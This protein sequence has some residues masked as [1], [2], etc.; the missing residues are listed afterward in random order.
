MAKQPRRVVS[1]ATYT[2]TVVLKVTRDRVLEIAGLIGKKFKVPAYENQT[3]DVLVPEPDEVDLD[4]LSAWLLARS[5]LS[6]LAKKKTNSLLLPDTVGRTG[7]VVSR[8]K[9]KPYRLSVAGYLVLDY[10]VQ[11]TKVDLD[12]LYAR[13][14]PENN[15]S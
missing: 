13:M 5:H 7:E 12:E 2:N 1:E 6:P 8:L 3:W 14:H 15:E 4:K 9:Q 11:Q 10:F